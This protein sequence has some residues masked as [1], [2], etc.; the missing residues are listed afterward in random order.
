[1]AF[2]VSVER[3][4]KG[5]LFLELLNDPGSSAQ[6]RGEGSVTKHDRIYIMS[7]RETKRLHIIHQALD[8]RI[9]QKTA[10]ELVGLSSKQIRRILRRVRKEG[11]D[12]ISHR[13]RGKTSN[14]RLSQ[15]LKDKVL[16]LYRKQYGDFGPTFA[17]EKLLDV[18]KIK[19]SD[20]TL[21]LWLNQENISYEK[22]KGRKHR[23]WR[24]RKHPFD[25]MVQMD[26]SHHAWFEGRGP[27]SV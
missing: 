8:K 6:G 24:E 1:L 9:T 14:R 2:I 10:A 13:S 22:R 4:Q 5:Q 11:D 12:G 7:R 26:G 16:K 17:C 23:Q 25:E 15:N 27:E 20:E 21:R 18:H 19:L 3:A